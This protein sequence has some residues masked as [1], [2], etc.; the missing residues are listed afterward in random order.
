M[1]AP[2]SPAAH[3]ESEIAGLTSGIS[4]IDVDQLRSTQHIEENFA[5]LRAEFRAALDDRPDF[6]RWKRE[7]LAFCDI[8]EQLESLRAENE[9]LKRR[10]DALV[11]E[12]NEMRGVMDS[13]LT[14]IERWV[15]SADLG[16][17]VRFMLAAR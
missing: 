7:W 16:D 9:E 13:Q 6:E 4:G 17:L 10:N 8:L 12:L 1:S 14:H 11:A 5:N 3:P 2:P 15:R